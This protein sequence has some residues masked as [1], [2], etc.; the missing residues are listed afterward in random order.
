M[1]AFVHF[2]ALHFA[3]GERVGVEVSGLPEDL[4]LRGVEQNV[5]AIQGEEVGALPHVAGVH[6]IVADF[7]ARGAMR[8]RM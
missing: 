5:E 7:A 3:E 1:G 6:G 8:E 4:A 2:A